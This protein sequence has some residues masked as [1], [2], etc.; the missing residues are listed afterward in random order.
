MRGFDLVSGIW[1]GISCTYS[2]NVN[3]NN[4]N[5]F[6]IRLACSLFTFTSCALSWGLLVCQLPLLVFYALA[7]VIPILFFTMA[8]S[9][10][11]TAALAL[12][13]SLTITSTTLRHSYSYGH[14]ALSLNSTLCD[15]L[16]KL[17]IIARRLCLICFQGLLF[18]QR[19]GTRK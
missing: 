19:L 8:A 6:C 16:R 14:V 12:S 4:N 15:T 7:G 5:P 1:H 9:V 13:S 17:T 18:L 3:N 10:I 11:R 2:R